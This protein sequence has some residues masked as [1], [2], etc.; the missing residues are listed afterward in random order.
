[1]KENAPRHGL[2]F[3]WSNSASS[4]RLSSAETLL[5]GFHGLDHRLLQVTVAF[6]FGLDRR[7]RIE[8]VT[9]QRGPRALVGDQLIEQRSHFL[10][11]HVVDGKSPAWRRQGRRGHRPTAPSPLFAAAP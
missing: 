4:R 3:F 1:M 8:L 7:G 6:H 5:A 2:A 11:G 10:V 9:S